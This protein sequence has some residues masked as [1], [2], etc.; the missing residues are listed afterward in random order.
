MH[1]LVRRNVALEQPDGDRKVR[2]G[3]PP[4]AAEQGQD[5]SLLVVREVIACQLRGNGRQIVGGASLGLLGPP[6][7][8]G[9]REPVRRGR[10]VLADP[11]AVL[12]LPCDVRLPGRRPA[13]PV[14]VSCPRVDPECRLRGG[15]GD[16]QWRDMSGRGLDAVTAFR[17]I[18]LLN[19]G[20]GSAEID[21]TVL[22][23]DVK[24]C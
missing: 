6:V 12:L 19:D 18:F 22:G 4:Q 5:L 24:K 13:L 8:A 14:D 21:V 3:K 2:R 1:H 10:R 9:R 23:S 16:R 20:S 17:V 15:P 11:A 7:A